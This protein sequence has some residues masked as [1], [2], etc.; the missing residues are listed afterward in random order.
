MKYI[1]KTTSFLI[2][3]V[4]LLTGIPVTQ[5]QAASKPVISS[6]QVKINKNYCSVKNGKKIKLA[7]KYR[8]KDITKKCTWKSSKKSVATI[9]KA[10]VLTAKKAWTTYVTVKYKGK[11]SKKLKIVVKADTEPASDSDNTSSKGF[12]ITYNK[13]SKNKPDKLNGPATQKITAASGEILKFSTTVTPASGK[14]FLGWYDAP[15]G[16]SRIYETYKPTD[17]MTLK[18]SLKSP[19]TASQDY[20][21]VIPIIFTQQKLMT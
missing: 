11:T 14:K 20:T 7:A 18:Q 4:I 15:A 12:I 13:N 10:G 5:V 2:T 8:K 1:I 16:G 6:S 21:P 19:Y 3:L 9:S 17:D